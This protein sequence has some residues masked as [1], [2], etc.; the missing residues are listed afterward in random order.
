MAGVLR[1]V[2][3]SLGVAVLVC[4]TAQGEEAGAAGPP[5][6]T[7]SEVTKAVHHDA[8]PPLWLLP[9]AP[10]VQ[11]R[12]DNEPKRVPRPPLR[13][14][15]QADAALQAEVPPGLAPIVLLNVEGVGQGFIGP[16][17]TFFVN[18]APP[19][20]N[21]DVGPNHYVQTVNTDFAVFNKVGTPLFGPVPIN[22]LWSGFP[23]DCQTNNDGDPVVLYDPI[24]DRWIISQLS[25]T[26]ANGTTRP[27]LQ[28]V[29]VSQT[30]DPTGGYYRYAFPYS[31]FNDYPKLGVWPDAY[32]VT[33]NMFNAAGTLFMGGKAC[34]YDR[35]RMLLGL[36][37]TQQCFNTS[38]LFGGLLPA[39]L[40]GTRL[41]PAG[42]SNPVVALGS[43]ANQLAV[44]KFHTDWA[45]PANSTF[46]G[47][48]TLATA[49]FSEACSSFSGTC[50][51]QLGGGS[52]DSLG[53]RLMFRLAYRNFADG[54][55]SLVVNHSI[56]VGSHTGV[57]WY[58][59]RLD[60]GGNPSLFQQGTYA[61]DANYRW[62]GSIAQDQNGNMALGFSVSAS[63]IKPQIHYTGRLAGDPAGQ[64]TQG[65]GVVID[66]AGAQGAGLSRWGDY[67]MM[68]IDP[69]DD[70][71]FW[72]TTEYIPFNGVF[73]WRTRISS[74]RFPECTDVSPTPVIT[75][76]INGQHPSPPVV[77]VAGPTVLTLDVSPGSYTASVDWYWALSYN[78]TLYWV[79]SGGLSTT[80]APWFTNPP[81]ALTNVTLLNL[82]LPPA[83][84]MTNVIFMVNGGTTV[85]FDYITATRP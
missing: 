61:P 2:G 9:P 73:N 83:S 54:H 22:T 33:F 3:V 13:R 69:S 7:R 72:Y 19:D 12:P 57:R 50:I 46:T 82:N 75:L 42:A 14:R 49:A 67:S 40:D 26:G 4:A 43:A 45:I 56:T 11:P 63:T 6:R 70:C 27:F 44:W 31:G 85:S 8:S 10:K 55:Q 25:V 35:A 62:M 24:A 37:A 58:E 68:A 71:T 30:S 28:C 29:A 53:D 79:T 64:M 5:D 47:P 60:P 65:E 51:P 18:A 41:P 17:G 84:S 23:G 76:K 15:P 38:I 81:V 34:A 39:A 52:L 16:A 59:L 80:P 74:F 48:T 77:T 1:R 21:G 78:G 20:T 66:G 36:S 32:Y